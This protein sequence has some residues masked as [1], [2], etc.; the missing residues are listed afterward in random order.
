MKRLF[1][2][3]A[4]MIT[5][6]SDA[7]AQREVTGRVTDSRDGS[8][9]PSASVQIRGKEGGTTTNSDGRYR[10][11]AA[12]GEVLVISSINFVR[13]E[14]TVSGASHDV[15]L[16]FDDQASLR[17]VVIT[18]YTVQNRREATASIAKISGAEVKFQP[19]AS[20]DQL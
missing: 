8:L 12:A 3:S 16:Q 11:T 19:V 13:Q 17:E 6:L 14:V 2:L 4:L 20:F 1:L 10:I 7:M 9:V 5:L 15:V 18:G